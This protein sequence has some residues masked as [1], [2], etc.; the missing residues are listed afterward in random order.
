[1]LDG[2]SNLS[3]E[4]SLFGNR[5]RSVTPRYSGKGF[6]LCGGVIQTNEDPRTYK[7]GHHYCAHYLSKVY[8]G[9]SAADGLSVSANHFIQAPNSGANHSFQVIHA[10]GT[11]STTTQPTFS[12]SNRTVVSDGTNNWTG[13]GDRSTTYNGAQHPAQVRHPPQSGWLDE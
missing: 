5:K 2:P 12:G 7:C 3:F 9:W 10:A 13:W 4:R 6:E 11:V 8:G 1:M